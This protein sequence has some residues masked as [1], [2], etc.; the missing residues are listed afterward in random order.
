MQ[1]NKITNRENYQKKKKYYHQRRIFALEQINY[2]TQ[3]E[4]NDWKKRIKSI[5]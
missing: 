1:E 5:C 2:R 3:V 4:L